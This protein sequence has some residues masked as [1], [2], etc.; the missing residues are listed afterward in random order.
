MEVCADAT[1]AAPATTRA[2]R[3]ATTRDVGESDTRVRISTSEGRYRPWKSC[4]DLTVDANGLQT[5]CSAISRFPRRFVLSAAR[6]LTHLGDRYTVRLRGER[7][8]AS[9]DCLRLTGPRGLPAEARPK[10]RDPSTSSGRPEPRRGTKAG[11]I[12][13]A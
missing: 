5:L 9:A 12:A 1:G 13:V 2:S 4:G 7:P 10:P 6:C 11:I 8:H 3:A